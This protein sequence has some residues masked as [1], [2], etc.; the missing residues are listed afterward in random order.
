MVND[1]LFPYTRNET[2]FSEEATENRMNE[3]RMLLFV[4]MTRARHTLA[5]LTQESFDVRPSRL[6]N[7]LDP[8]AVEIVR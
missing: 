4:G 2:D 6:L 8:D 5:L 3:A 1:D 7:E